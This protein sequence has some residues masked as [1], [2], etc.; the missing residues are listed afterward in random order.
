[1]T[2]VRHGHTIEGPAILE[3]E[4]TTFAVPPDR[5]TWLDQNRVFHLERKEG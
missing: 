1:M 5:R 2:D 4:S 3:A